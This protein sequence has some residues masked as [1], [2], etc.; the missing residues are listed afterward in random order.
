MDQPKLLQLF[1]T[2]HGVFE[3]HVSTGEQRLSCTCPGFKLRAHCAHTD[4][5][6]AHSEE[7]GGYVVNL[8]DSCS[9]PSLDDMANPE[10]WRQFVLHNAPVVTL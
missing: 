7:D 1:L 4:Y 10:T 5:I 3:V 9:L 6:I 8:P 2:K